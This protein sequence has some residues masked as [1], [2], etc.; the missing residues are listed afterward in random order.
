M[1]FV[2]KT[3]MYWLCLVLLFNLSLVGLGQDTQAK[4]QERISFATQVRPLLAAN[5]FG[6]HQGAIDRGNYVMTDFLSM[7]AGGESGDPAI[8]PGKLEESRLI[9][10]TTSHDGK[11]EMPPNAEPLT[12]KDL[13]II[14]Q[15]ISEG[16][17][18]DYSKPTANYSNDN[19]PSYSRLPMVTTLDFSPDGK[20]IAVSGFHEVLLLK[21]ADNW[22]AGNSNQ[23]VPG[24]ISKRLIGLSSRIDGVKYSPDGKHL[25]VCGGN[26]GEF[27]EIQVWDVQTGELSLSKTVSYDTLYGVNWSP[28]GKTISF[29]CTDTTLRTINAVTGEQQLFQGAHDDWVRDTVFSK[30]GT[31]LVSVGRDMSCK[32]TDVA[33][34]RFIDNITSITPGVL[35]GGIAA[36]DRHPTR[37]EIVIGGADGIPK[38]YRMDRLT[39]RVIG[40]DANLI[41]ELPKMPGRVQSIVVSDD[42]KRI[43]A[44]SSLDG[45]GFVNVYSYEFDTTQPANIKAIVSKVVTSQSKE[46]KAA[47]REFVTKDVKQIFDSKITT[48]GLYSIAFHPN[49][50]FLAV[51][52]TDGLIR[53]MNSETGEMNQSI[54]TVKTDTQQTAQQTP[55]WKFAPLSPALPN[56]NI[57]T[58]RSTPT[59]LVVSPA[60]ISFKSPI[61][62][63]QLVIQAK[64][65]DG[66]LVDVTH[67]CN[68]S[69]D[70]PSAT[71][72]QTL[73]EAGTQGTGILKVEYND[74]QKSLAV[75][76]KFETSDFAPNFVQHVNPVLTKLGCN[77]GTCHGSQGGKKGFKLSLRGYDPIYDIRAFTDDM[78]SRRTNLSASAESM[79]L[80]KPTGQIPHEGGKLFDKDSRHYS[81]IHQWIK[82]GAKLDQDVAQVESIEVFPKNPILVDADWKQQMRVVATYSDGTRK[83]VTQEAVIEIGDIEIAAINGSVVKALRRGESAALARFEGAFTATT[84]TV[85]GD[86]DN[87]VWEK[88]EAWGEIDR[89]VADKWERMK[90]TPSDLCTD[91][92]FL[93]RV[94][95][96]LTGL[97]PNEEQVKTFLA[98]AQ[99]TRTKRSKLIDQLVGNEQFVEHWANKRADLLQVNRKYLGAPGASNLRN[100]IREQVKTNRPYNDFS[101]DLLTASGSNKDNPAASY[102]KIHRTPEEAMENTTHLFLATRFNCNKCHD[103]PF[104]KWTQDQ[105]YETAAYF[106]QIDRKTDPQ[107]KGKKIGGTAVEG[108]KPLYEIISDKPDGEVK[109]ERT[110]EIANPLFPFSVDV[111][112]P[113]TANRRE[114]LASWITSAKNPYFATSHVNRLWGYLTGVGLI[115][116]I[117]DIRAGNPPSNPALIEYLRAQFIESGFDTQHIIK[118]ICNSRTYQLSVSTNGF[119]S[120]DQRNY[121]HAIARRLPAEVLFD[122][123][124]EVT[125]SVLNI[126]GVNPGTRA[127][128]LPD[129]GVRLPSGF[130][131]TLGRPPRESACECER[132]NELQLGSVL[133][134]VSG[135]DV[136]RAVGDPSSQIAQLVTSEPDNAQLIDRLFMRILNRHASPQEL[137]VLKSAFLEIDS[138]HTALVAARD[139]Q[140]IESDKARPAAEK[141]RLEN[142]KKTQEKL[143]QLTAKTA[144]NLLQQ[145][146]DRLTNIEKIKQEINE[147]QSAR[148]NF[149]N[150]LVKQ[151]KEI[152][153]QAIEPTKLEST[154]GNAFIVREDK[155]ILL[156]PKPGKDLYTIFADESLNGTTAIRLEVL[157]DPS[158]PGNGPGLAP[159]GNIVLTEFEIEI[160][161]PDQPD[162]WEKVKISTSASNITQPNFSTA[163]VIDGNSTNQRGWALA[164]A[165]GKISWATFHL[166][167]PLNLPEGAKIRFRMHQNF[168]ENHQIG[169][170]RISATQFQEP[171][172]LSLPDHLV[173]EIKVPVSELSKAQTELLKG[174]FEKD[175]PTLR[176]L[177]A[178]LANAEKMI[179]VPADVQKMREKLGR[180]ELPV[181]ADAKLQR[182]EADVITSQ[183]QL[184]NRRLTA[185]QDLTWALINSPSFLF[186]R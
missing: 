11:A 132:V 10:V 104:E 181:P 114:Q 155:S 28:D 23:P 72:N 22:E 35:K 159:N 81:L 79:M 68:I 125:G 180:Y 2:N 73:I 152:N 106:A 50:K 134:L 157:S 166:E 92:E 175:D 174:L 136:S 39:K 24:E 160:A 86:R 78:A 150:W 115:E 170:F 15:W 147:F 62:Y 151:Q 54:R 63:A 172:N 146:A 96:D 13:D 25:A 74:L 127:A 70:T 153:W 163:Q 95:L 123:I 131:A 27:G 168:D 1:G 31:R 93:R 158:L 139:K 113:E 42:G 19:P 142:I 122:S 173:A 119:N 53:I 7:L 165:I 110:G 77:A 61:D 57:G 17:V 176:D 9:E 45:Q 97:P 98:D 58:L 26:P 167:A 20:Q 117:D 33:T 69:S 75:E 90:I 38:V 47:L 16:A 94:Y 129:S 109:H 112:I 128:A 137:E 36:I 99:E 14:R 29:G 87:F 101:Y 120:D 141:L 118:L 135:P 40:D 59:E 3:A 121:S 100:W 183:K 84:I 60:D 32:L 21:V 66:Q 46:E 156:K 145:E 138:D 37:D 186:N 184:E 49:G 169:A 34:Q 154:L 143:S 140:K 149:S 4:A 85:M 164:N 65:P 71:V 116:P 178:K 80:L 8:V 161:K 30:D 171:V 82:N 108:A 182:L 107:S 177:T 102:Y 5:C 41:R 76:T 111:A 48:G 126:P 51:G 6:C 52:G 179:A 133:A 91:A 12:S 55:N 83:D 18:N 130:L 64:Y 148:S 185:T 44:A 43:A 89:F 88:P 67:A 144:P 162:K 124:H 56:Q 103:H 105:Y